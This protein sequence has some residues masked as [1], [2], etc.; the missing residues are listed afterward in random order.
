M[1]KIYTIILNFINVKILLFLITIVLTI[2]LTNYSIISVKKYYNE[3]EEKN[4]LDSIGKIKIWDTSYPLNGSGY[5]KVFLSTKYINGKIYYILLL[6][7]NAENGEDKINNLVKFILNFTDKD[8]FTLFHIDLER[9]KFIRVSD[10]S[11]NL[12]AIRFEGDELLDKS[13]YLQFY[14]YDMLIKTE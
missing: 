3:K 10:S 4:I 13:V 7:I 1:K 5:D 8:N 12:I 9:D 11:N 2:F 6:D 14:K